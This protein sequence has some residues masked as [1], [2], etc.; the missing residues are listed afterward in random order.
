MTAINRLN[1]GGSIRISSA[2]ATTRQTPRNDFGAMIGRGVANGAGAVAGAVGVAAPFIPGGAV[3]SSTVSQAAGAIGNYA[4]DG[5]MN[6]PGQAP[7]LNTPMGQGGG[8]STQSLMDQ[9][10]QMQEMQMSFNLQYLNLQNKMQGENR[11]YSTI[12]NVLK[13]KHDTTK[14]SINN[15]R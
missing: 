14:N 4:N 11:Q 8:S 7:G 6:M 5:G 9:T 1:N 13:T 2:P 10:K 12:S 15:I 3:V